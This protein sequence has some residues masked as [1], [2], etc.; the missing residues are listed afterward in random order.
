MA[1]Y[2]DMISQDDKQI[3][4][5]TFVYITLLVASAENELTDPEIHEAVNTIKVRG[6]E[7]NHLFHEFYDEIGQTFEA[8]LSKARS[9]HEIN[10]ASEDY[11]A[12]RISRV[13]EVLEK[14]PVSVA[15]RLYKDYKSFAHRIAN[16][17]GGILGFGTIS[18]EE[19][20]LIELPMI[21]PVVHDDE[22]E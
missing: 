2:F 4:Q 3:L 21:I 6:Y 7:A 17:D 16:A 11:Y 14:L 18:R 19:R 5:E 1:K 15:K 9:E 12:R 20:N 10:R 13:N 22:E 8:D